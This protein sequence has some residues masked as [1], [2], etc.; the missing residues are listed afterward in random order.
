MLLATQYEPFAIRHLQVALR[1]LIKVEKIGKEGFLLARVF[2]LVF[3][4]VS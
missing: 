2:L 3:T 1:Y 4:A